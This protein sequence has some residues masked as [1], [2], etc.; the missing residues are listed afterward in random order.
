[1]KYNELVVNGCSYMHAYALGDG[2]QHLAGLLG[3]ATATSIAVSGS[4][5]GRILR[6]TVKHS[7]TASQPTFYVMGMTFLSRDELPILKPIND[8][9]GRWS[10]PQNQMFEKLWDYP[11]TWKD[12]KRYVDLKLKWECSSIL[13]RAEDLQ[14]RILSTV[15][16]LRSRGHTVLVY[17]QADDVFRAFYDHPKLAHFKNCKYI[18]GD[19]SWRSVPWQHSQGVPGTDYGVNLTAPVPPEMVHPARGH[20]RK[21]NEYLTDY[22]QQHKI[23]E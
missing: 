2:H 9:E 23:L 16:D 13:D 11:W 17:N 19:Y 15:N 18:V 3:I 4:A 14:Y 6:T 21:I 5:N 8:F 1:M 22:I 10:N 20:H 7:Y 12:T